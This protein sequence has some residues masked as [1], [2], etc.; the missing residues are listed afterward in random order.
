MDTVGTARYLGSPLR[1]TLAEITFQMLSVQVGYSPEDLGG[2]TFH[3]SY[4][5]FSKDSYQEPQ[6]TS[7]HLFRE[8]EY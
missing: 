5:N 1:K 7:F 2:D 8:S 3:P 4:Q 6:V